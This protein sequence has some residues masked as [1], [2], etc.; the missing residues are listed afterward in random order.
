[1]T[2]AGMLCKMNILPIAC[3]LSFLSFSRYFVMGLNQ[4]DFQR[5]NTANA[6]DNDTM[7]RENILENILSKYDKRF[8]PLY[9][10]AQ[11]V[12][13]KVQIY[14]VGIFGIDEAQ[15]KYS[16]SMYLRQQWTDSR[17]R[18]EAPEG[19]T[20]I[21]LDNEIKKEI[22]VPDLSFMTDMDTKVHQVTLPNK[23]MFL[24]PDGFVS[25][26]TR[27]TG[28]FTCFMQLHNFPFDDQSCV[29]EMESYGFTAATVSFRWDE[30]GMSFKDGIVHSQF[31]IG[32]AETYL[33]D[34]EY[35][36][37]NYTCI[38]LT[39]PLKRRYGFYIIQVFA[40]SMLIV[41]LS[42]VS[43][44]LNIDAAPARVS[45]GILTVLTISTNG[46][47]SVGMSQQVSYIRAIDI[48]NS[49][50]L[51]LVFGAMV[52]YAYVCVIARVQQRR[53]RERL[54]SNISL[55]GLADIENGKIT[56]KV[57]EQHQI[58]KDRENARKID[59]IARIAFPLAFVVFNVIYWVYYMR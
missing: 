42:W 11:P 31:E 30:P 43:F 48:W 12:E 10:K 37:G 53:K 49:V 29:Y 17:L 15:M 5:V 38:G 2:E 7:I 52:E 58:D 4:T 24:Y 56:E 9:N 26:S 23:M 39:L 32:A 18:Y 28:T 35:P 16:M 33:C 59:K 34:R 55:N 47:L 25:Y 14:V 57:T 22:W 21:E 41:V 54:H 27:V 36:S 13:V 1:M 20:K 40:P 19:L 44:W 51:F 46:N 50:C 45:L 8:P 3:I 6:A